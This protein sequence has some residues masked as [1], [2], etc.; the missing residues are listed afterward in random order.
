MEKNGKC[1]T[2]FRNAG[3]LEIYF[4]KER[5]TKELKKVKMKLRRSAWQWVEKVEPLFMRARLSRR[6]GGKSE[7]GFSRLVSHSDWTTL[8]LRVDHLF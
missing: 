5:W 2:A 3:N 1:E 8:T 4:E 6:K 7:N